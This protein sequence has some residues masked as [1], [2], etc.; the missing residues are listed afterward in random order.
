MPSVTYA[1]TLPKD[2]RHAVRI[3]RT[4]NTIKRL[5]RERR[6]HVFWLLIYMC[7]SILELQET[8]DPHLPVLV[9]RY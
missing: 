1:I 7:S 6:Y 3:L 8:Q 2:T 4:L 5:L 9:H